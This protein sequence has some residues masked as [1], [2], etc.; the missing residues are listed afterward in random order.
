MIWAIPDIHGRFDLFEKLWEKLGQE[1]D[2]AKDDLYYLGDMVDRGPQSREVIQ[3]IRGQCAA[4]PNNV[5]ALRGNH[6]QMM[7]DACLRKGYDEEYLWKIN[8]GKNTLWSY[9]NREDILE[10][11]LKWLYSL[12]LSIESDGF[13]FSHAPVPREKRRSTMAGKPF[14]LHELIWNYPANG[15]EVACSRNFKTD[16]DKDLIGVCGHVHALNKHPPVLGPRFYDHYYFLDSGCG[17]WD[18]APLVAVEVTTRRTIFA[19]QGTS[20]PELNE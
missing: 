4:S 15:D 18:K 11:D 6:E 19:W 2:L 16:D 8:G 10:D 9:A 1:I 17:C 20:M 5:F 7:M 14:A 12:P 3:A 13:F